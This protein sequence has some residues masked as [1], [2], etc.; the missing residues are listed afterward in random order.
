MSLVLQFFFFLF[1]SYGRTRKETIGTSSPK[2]RL[3]GQVLCPSQMVWETRTQKQEK[4]LPRE[5]FL[6]SLASPPIS[7]ENIK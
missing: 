3:D 4:R 6:F 2:D 7:K 5:I 1:L